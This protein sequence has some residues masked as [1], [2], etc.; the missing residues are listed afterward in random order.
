METETI[1][2]LGQRVSQELENGKTL[3]ESYKYLELYK[4]SDWLDYFYKDLTE[5]QKQCK[6]HRRFV[7]YRDKNVDVVLI[8]WNPHI[9]CQPHDHPKGGCLLKVMN[10][11]LKEREFLKTTE[12]FV[13]KQYNLLREGS[14][15]YQ[16]GDYIHSIRNDL[17]EFSCS[18]HIY[19][20]SNYIPKK[21]LFL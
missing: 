1:A 14:I 20:P 8:I 17:D 18:L 16:E 7:I 12:C 6:S 4:G 5:E 15:Y 9:E 13:F 21:Y 11:Y 2:E 3:R 19:A 10:G